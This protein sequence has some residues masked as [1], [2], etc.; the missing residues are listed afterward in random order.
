MSMDIGGVAAL[1]IQ[2]NALDSVRA[3]LAQAQSAPSTPAAQAD[4]ILTL[5]TGA[6]ALI[7]PNPNS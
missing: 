1:K 7:T 2:A 4:V 6:A 3:V 5:S